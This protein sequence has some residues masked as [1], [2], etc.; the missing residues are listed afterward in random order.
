MNRR[1]GLVI[2]V[3]SCML[4][5]LWASPQEP[6]KKPEGPKPPGKPEGGKPQGP[7]GFMMGGP[8][9][10]ERKLVKE[11]DKDGDGRLNAE[12]RKTAREA[13]KKERAAGGRGGFGFGPPGGRGG[14]GPGGFFAKPLLDALDADKDLKLTKDELSAGVRKLMEDADKEKKGLLDEGQLAEALNRIA[15]PPQ[16]FPGGPPQGGRGGPPGGF[17]MFGPGSFLAN[18]IVRRADADKDAKLTLKELLAAAES[19]L[20]E[21]DKDKDGKL[22]ET[23]LGGAFALLTPQPGFG[24]PGFGR[25][26]REPPKPGPRLT[27][28]DVKSYA[29]VPLYEPNVLRTLFLEFENQDWEAELADFQRTDVELP[30]TLTVDG[31]KYPN[32]GVHF[33][34]MSSLFGVGEGYKR[35]LNLSL[36][37]VDPKQRLQ[38]Y[39][40]LNLLN[41][42]ED[43]A[44]LHTVLYSHIARQYLPAPKA[45]LVKVVINGESW[46]LYVNAQQFDRAFLAE[47][48]PSAKGT[49]WKVRGS[50][51][52]R[53]GLEYLGE[54]VEEYKRRYE[55]KTEDGDK[56]WK[57]L[58]K[59][60]RTLNQTPLDKLEEALKPM[61]DIDGVLWF[62]AVEN[63]LINNDGYW[64]RASDYSLFLDQKGK[65]HIIP[66]DMNEAFGPAMM[67]FGPGGGF[68]RGFG[69]SL[70]RPILE[71]ADQNKDKK[72]ATEEF[73]E[74]AR[75]FFKQCDAEK[76]G[77]I[78][79]KGIA[80]GLNRLLLPPG[81]PGGEGSKPGGPS[82]GGFPGFVPGPMAAGA[83]LKKAGVDQAGKLTLEQFVKTAE[84]FF[85]ECDKDKNGALDE[86]ELSAGINGLMP[87]PRGF[88][89]GPP[90]APGAPGVEPVPIVVPL[91][92]PPTDVFVPIQ[93]PGGPG[94]PG[95]GGPRGGGVELDP[96]NGLEDATKPLRSKLL[97]V[98]GLKTRYL[99]HVRTIADEWLDWNKLKPIVES[100]RSLI[101][102]EVGADTRKLSSYDSF[103]NILDDARAEQGPPGG[104]RGMSLR[105]FAEQR[106]T[107]LLSHPEIKKLGARP[108]GVGKKEGGE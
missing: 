59:L 88:F 36:D 23:E 12:E 86:S 76:K 71:A 56:A 9:G 22:D 38:E 66:H 60:C 93:G 108:S 19:L 5:S 24:P 53:G 33:R 68:A 100:Y 84:A 73:L 87:A 31:K 50:P 62:L 46:G 37:F 30:V 89:A 1:F 95:P 67:M 104:R 25:E 39:K 101:E 26:N 28:A 63:A 94:K 61:L 85:Q 16:P 81:P 51:G 18:G 58:I 69:T 2:L 11:F 49:R 105:A 72:L 102:S 70:I 52:G 45:N 13:I 78:D 40:T 83:I 79:E 21:T 3:G 54:N 29:G 17:R 6:G 98:P 99:Q 27:P 10:G 82:R 65:F 7:G 34:G 35:S 77:V 42:H 90:A 4:T 48:Y 91:D 103:K 32:V 20:K 8:M 41:A 75:R 44:F 64:I 96:L 57:A 55:L 47:N 43:P 92:K 106:R 80:D 107:F 74:G 14:F 97:A 15:P